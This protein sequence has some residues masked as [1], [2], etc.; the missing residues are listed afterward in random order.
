MAQRVE[1]D[2][3][4]SSCRKRSGTAFE[5]NDKSDVT[6][7]EEA[8]GLTTYTYDGDGYRRS[9]HE[10]GGALTTFVRRGPDIVEEI[11]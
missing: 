11:S 4:P 8:S 3:I 6:V 10:P 2:A 7:I 1:S 9:Q 5:Y